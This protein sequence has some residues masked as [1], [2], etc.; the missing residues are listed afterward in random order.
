LFHDFYEGGAVI[1]LR[2]DE[3]PRKSAD[4]D[5]LLYHAYRDTR[6]LGIRIESPITYCEDCGIRTRGRF[7]LCPFCQSAN[8]QY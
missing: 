8:V 6:A 5:S 2:P 3:V 7:E 4:L 1:P